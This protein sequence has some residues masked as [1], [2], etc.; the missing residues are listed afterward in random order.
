MVAEWTDREP[1]LRQSLGLDRWIDGMTGRESLVR[2]LFDTTLNVAGI[3]GGYSGAG[4]KT[5]LPHVATA[6]LDSRLVPDQTPEQALGLIRAH[7]DARGFGD[8]EIRLLA[9]YPPAQSSVETA[10]VRAVIGAYNKHGFTPSVAPRAAGSAPY[11]LF[12]ERLD[13]PM[14]SAGLGFGTGA[15]APNEYM[16]IEPAPGSRIAGLA[17]TEKFYVDLLYALAG[18]R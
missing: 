12:T 3:W 16:V 13:V 11:Y 17:R 5:V 8:L 2:R 9:G 6:K 14:V 4:T 18:A 10:L 7:L 1:A 15:H